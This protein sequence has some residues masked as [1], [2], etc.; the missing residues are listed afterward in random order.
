MNLLIAKVS[1]LP[2][3]PSSKDRF[4]VYFDIPMLL[5][6]QIAY[7]IEVN[8][9]PE[10]GDEILVFELES[11]FGVSYLYSKLH[12]DNFI[13]FCIGNSSIKLTNDKIEMKGSSLKTYATGGGDGRGLVNITAIETLITA[14]ATDLAT[15]QSGTALSGWV[16]SQQ[17]FLEDT[18]ITH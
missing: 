17:M 18:T 11:V 6:E 15:A 5:T 2:N 4:V 10:V 3:S 1:K 9:Q 7:P 8:E 14:L 16:S 13:R 12:L